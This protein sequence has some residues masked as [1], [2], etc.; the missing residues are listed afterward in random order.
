MQIASFA[1][2]L[3]EMSKPISVKNKK[4]IQG[5]SSSEF[6]QRVIIMIKKIL[7]EAPNK[8]KT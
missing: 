8:T 2:S 7:T 4:N 1:D 5:L 3:H 6:A